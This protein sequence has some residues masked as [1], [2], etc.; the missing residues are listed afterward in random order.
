MQ[1]RDEQTMLWWLQELQAQRRAYNVNHT[2][3]F[4]GRDEWHGTI[5]GQSLFWVPNVNNTNPGLLDM[6]PVEKTQNQ[7]K[8]CQ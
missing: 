1:A 2:D 4:D 8:I 5:L 6:S 3:D 7:G